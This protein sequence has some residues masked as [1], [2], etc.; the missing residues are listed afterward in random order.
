VAEVFI[1]WNLCHVNKLNEEAMMEQTHLFQATVRTIRL[2][3]KSQK[4]EEGGGVSS[5]SDGSSI[6]LRKTR[7]KTEFVKEAVEVV[8]WRLCY[9]LGHSQVVLLFLIL[10]S[11][12]DLAGGQ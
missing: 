10:D 11:S 1:N 12:N 8:S 7:R 5:G 6:L 3:M 4:R 2:K 9:P